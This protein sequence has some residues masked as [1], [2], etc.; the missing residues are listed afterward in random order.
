MDILKKILK[1][2][3]LVL[4]ILTIVSGLIGTIF[5]YNGFV[6]FTGLISGIFGFLSIICYIFC[7]IF[8]VFTIVEMLDYL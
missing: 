2:K 6:K 1:M 4:S 8:L 5:A 7:F 3:P